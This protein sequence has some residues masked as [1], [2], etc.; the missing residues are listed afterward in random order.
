MFVVFGVA[1][2]F[3]AFFASMSDEFG[4]GSGATSRSSR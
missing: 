3:G 4:A 2:S 1:Y